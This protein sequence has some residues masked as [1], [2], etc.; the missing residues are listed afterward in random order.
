MDVEWHKY[1]PQTKKGKNKFE[2]LRLPVP[3]GPDFVENT[4][5]VMEW[6]WRCGRDATSNKAPG[7]LLVPMRDRWYM[8]DHEGYEG[9]YHHACDPKKMLMFYTRYE[10]RWDQYLEHRKRPELHM[11]I[12]DAEGACRDALWGAFN[13]TG[14]ND[15]FWSL[16]NM[17][18]FLIDEIV[19]SASEPKKMKANDVLE[20]HSCNKCQ[21]PMPKSIIITN[22][23]SRSKLVDIGY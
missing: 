1:F 20:F 9:L 23:L 18:K 4:A 10:H 14:K 21:E 2:E 7:N 5:I 6:L 3:L 17:N 13:C 11:M 19:A 22:K 8:V 15:H 16:D 12:Q